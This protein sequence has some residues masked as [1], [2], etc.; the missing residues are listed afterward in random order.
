MAAIWRTYS[1]FVDKFPWGSN[2]L[3]TGVLCATG[4]VISQLVVER[5]PLSEF[6]WARVGKFFLIGSCVV[7]PCVRTWYLTLEKI[8]KFPGPKGAFSKMCLDQ[9]LFAP[10]FIVVF[11]SAAS[12]LNGLS[13]QE[14]VNNLRR[15]YTD[16]L[17]TNWKIWPA[18]QLAN[19]YFV[20][21][22]HRILV[23]NLVALFWNTYL[24]YKTNSHKQISDSPVE[25]GEKQS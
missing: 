18:T 23:V 9:S 7:A 20:P 6:E 17:L 2:I 3:Q 24:A 16:I 15:D 13:S 1:R 4:D 21:F 14:L 10:C 8:V 25:Q 19:F 11:V 5:K 22:Q 12:T